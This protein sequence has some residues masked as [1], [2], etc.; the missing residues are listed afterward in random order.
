[1]KKAFFNILI[2][3]ILSGCAEDTSVI[4]FSLNRDGNKNRIA[5]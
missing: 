3:F 5:E 4:V 1:M 2:F